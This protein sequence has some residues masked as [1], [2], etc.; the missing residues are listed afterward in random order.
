MLELRGNGRG[1]YLWGRSVHNTRSER[2]WVDLVTDLSDKWRRF[3]QDLETHHGMNAEDGYHTWLL[4][5]LFLDELNRE[6]QEWVQ[7]WNHHKMQLKGQ[8]NQLPIEMFMMGMVER[9]TP[10][11]REWIEQQEEDVD[12]LPN[13]G[14]AWENL[15]DE[16]AHNL[17]NEGENQGPFEIDNR[18]E[19]L[20]DVACDPPDCPLS[21][22]EKETLDVTVVHEFGENKFRSMP[23]RMLIWNRAFD[24]CRALIQQREG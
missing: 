7:S 16:V 15:E 10:G 5:H 13:Y 4:Q 20:H 2:L 11:V 17:E 6:L 24:L 21:A 18:P 1:S 12:D 8:L 3:F 19:Q 22:V 9:E 23:E 14:V